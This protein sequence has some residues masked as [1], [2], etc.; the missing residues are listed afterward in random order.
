M[1]IF[2]LCLS[3]NNFLFPDFSFGL[4]GKGHPIDAK[5]RNCPTCG[6]IGKVS[7][8]GLLCLIFC[9]SCYDDPVCIVFK[10]SAFIYFCF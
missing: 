4:D 10:T 3:E 2:L 7:S 1:E 9:H 6:G 8:I 5:A